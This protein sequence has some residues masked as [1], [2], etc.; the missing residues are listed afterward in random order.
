MIFLHHVMHH[1]NDVINLSVVAA[2]SLSSRLQTNLLAIF[3]N[4]KSGGG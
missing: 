4:D 2:P 3:T 1:E